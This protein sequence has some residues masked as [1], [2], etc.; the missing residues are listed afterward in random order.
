MISKGKESS[1]V[2]DKS[3]QAL[4]NEG[5]SLISSVF[6]LGAK[7]KVKGVCS[8]LEMFFDYEHTKV[9][10]FAHHRLMLDGL[11]EF[12]KKKKKGYIRIDGRVNS[13]ERSLRVKKF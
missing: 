12:L 4:K 1:V 5:L 6:Q 7:A 2:L 13:K 10:V 9:V 8:F 3:P 11:E